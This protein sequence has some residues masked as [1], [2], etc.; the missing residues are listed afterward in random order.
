MN[1]KKTVIN[2]AIALSL[3]AS[4]IAFNT[5]QAG[6]LATSVVQLSNFT[7]SHAAGSIVDVSEFDSLTFTSSADTSASFTGAAS[8][9]DSA[10]AAP[11]FTSDLYSQ[12][13]LT[14]PTAHTS[15]SDNDFTPLSSGTGWPDGNFAIGDQLESGSPISGFFMDASG[16]RVP[17]GT[18]GAT[19]V[20]P[21]AAL[22]NASYVS[23]ESTGTG[24]AASNNGLES[25]FSFSGISGALTFNFDI[26]AYLEAFLTPGEAA[27]STASSSFSVIFSLKDQTNPFAGE[28][29]LNNGTSAGG[30]TGLSGTFAKT[31]AANAPGTGIGGAFGLAPGVPFTDSF[32]LN[33]ATLDATHTYQLSARIL[34]AADATAVPAPGVLALIGTGLLGFGFTRKQRAK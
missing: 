8:A 23:V 11:N 12:A 27:P 20:T 25:K 29:V 2:A 32:T 14:A 1:T 33:T 34:T 10:A 6:A 13:V 21:N 19:A 5:A 28:M 3:S 26:S 16:A 4:A 31:G 18:P 7:I 22:S 17:S 15:Y 9:A 24:S 30:L